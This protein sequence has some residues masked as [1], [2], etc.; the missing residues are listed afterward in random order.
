MRLRTPRVPPLPD[1]E[2]NAEQRDILD[3]VHPL[4]RN[5]NLFRT[6]LRFPEAMKGLTAWGRYIQGRKNDLQGR[7][8]EIV[9]LRT[10]YRGKAA[11]E[12]SHHH[13]IGRETGLTDDELLALKD[14]RPDHRWNRADAVL[15]AACDELMADDFISDA[16]WEEM[17]RHFSP[18]EM[19]DIVLT[20]GHYAQVGRIVNALGIQI[21][22]GAH[23][24]PDLVDPI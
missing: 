12:W 5:A 16:T 4:A 1:T 7:F 6:M 24:D 8:K 13:R 18:K 22:A 20:S 9:I 14:R 19:V 11:Y 17:A 15:I 23:F 3:S 21:D 2:L 10:A